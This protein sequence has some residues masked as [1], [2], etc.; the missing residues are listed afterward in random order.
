MNSCS[1]NMLKYCG[2]CD[3]LTATV[4][5]S[6]SERKFLNAH[7]L[8]NAIA[9]TPISIMKI[10]DFN[11]YSVMLKDWVHHIGKSPNNWQA[12]I[13]TW[14]NEMN[15]QG[16]RYIDDII[17]EYHGTNAIEKLVPF[18]ME[19]L[20]VLAHKNTVKGDIT[21]RH[22]WVYAYI[23]TILLGFDTFAGFTKLNNDLLCE[24]RTFL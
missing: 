1:Y 10:R 8:E 9:Q 21:K 22:T 3:T 20:Q 5:L 24:I 14:H 19:E 11:V 13:T 16:I 15:Y 23:D 7:K 6:P 17:V 18:T 4:K 12:R 2:L